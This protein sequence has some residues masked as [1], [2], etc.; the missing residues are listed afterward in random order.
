M[1][2]APTSTRNASLALRRGR[3]AGL[4]EALDCAVGVECRIALILRQIGLP[5][6]SSGKLRRVRT[7]VQFIAGNYA[8]EAGPD[9]GALAPGA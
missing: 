5:L 6:T 8:D 3:F 7:K 2:L 4:C 9:R 1:G